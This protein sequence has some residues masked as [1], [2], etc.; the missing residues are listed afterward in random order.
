MGGFWNWLKGNGDDNVPEVEEV[1]Q[2]EEFFE[3][4]H[5]NNPEEFRK[6]LNDDINDENGGA[7]EYNWGVPNLFIVKDDALPGF[8]VIYGKP[9]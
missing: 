3:S 2:P 4:K 7:I 1:E 9:Q 6:W 5:F 8:T